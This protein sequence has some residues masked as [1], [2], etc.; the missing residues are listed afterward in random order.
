MV[1]SAHPTLVACRVRYVDID[2]IVVS[3]SWDRQL[4]VYDEN[5]PDHLTLLRRVND[6]HAADITCV[7]A[8]RDMS[9]IASGCADA[10]VHVWGYL[11]RA[12]LMARGAGRVVW[13]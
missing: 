8:S 12:V 7:H 3:V 6:A 13:L 9:L 1:A 2:K 4:R 11:V 5:D 10:T